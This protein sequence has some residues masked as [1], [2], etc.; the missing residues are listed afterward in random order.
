MG[1]FTRQ[2]HDV[3]R[4]YHLDRF[5]EVAAILWL[6][7]YGRISEF[8]AKAY[9]L[10]LRPRIEQQIACPNLLHPPP[11]EQQL[12]ANG[13]PD[14]ELGQLENGLR[15]GVRIKDRPR[16]MLFAGATGSGKTTGIR[17]LIMMIDGLNHE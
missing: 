17:K 4:Q 7:L 16:H 10:W 9:L 12:N 2:L 8:Q 11:D 6:I 5:P 1:R 15:F 14:I 13:P 3:I